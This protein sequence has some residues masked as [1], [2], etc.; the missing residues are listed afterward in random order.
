MSVVLG[1]K[2][3][4]F[5]NFRSAL[6][7]LS[8]AEFK[9]PEPAVRFIL[10][11]FTNFPALTERYLT[12]EVA[13][14]PTSRIAHFAGLPMSDPARWKSS[15]RRWNPCVDAFLSCEIKLTTAWSLQVHLLLRSLNGG[16]ALVE[17]FATSAEFCE[18]C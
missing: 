8:F 7:S 4:S 14:L 15:V 6:S 2:V 11:A 10:D 3:N 13:G 12:R 1:L 17:A 18:R 5:F 16:V 9:L